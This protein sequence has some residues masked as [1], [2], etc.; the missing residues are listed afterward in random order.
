MSYV[1]IILTIYAVVAK[2][3]DSHYL[4]KQLTTCTFNVNLSHKHNQLKIQSNKIH[5]VY[6]VQVNKWGKFLKNTMAR[7]WSGEYYKIIKN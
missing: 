6:N 2:H 3:L 1:C 5:P 7:H 4:Y